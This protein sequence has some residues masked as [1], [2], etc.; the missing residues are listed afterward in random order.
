MTN[1]I[2][3]GGRPVVGFALSGPPQPSECACKKVMG[4]GDDVTAPAPTHASPWAVALATSV[5]GAAAGWVIEEVARHVRKRP[6]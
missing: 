2:S 6:S 1:L 3:H 5:M 4:I